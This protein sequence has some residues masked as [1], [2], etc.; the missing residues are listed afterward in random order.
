MKSRK[1]F[2]IDPTQLIVLGFMLIIL[3]G[4]ML[5]TLPIASKEGVFTDFISALFTATSATCVTGLVVV[6]TYLYWSP[7]GQAVILI[8]IQIGGLG[9]MTMATLFS[10]AIRRNISYKERMLVAQSLSFFDMK[11]V[12]R[13]TRHILLG[14]L[15]FEGT[16]AVILS[17][18]LIPEFGIAGG[19]YRGIFLSVSSFCNAGFDLMGSKGA[20]SSLTT[21]VD[22]ITVNAVVASLIIIGGLG[23]IVW[24]ELYTLRSFTK[25]SVYSKIVLIS[26]GVLIIGGAILIFLSEAENPATLQPLSVQGK[27]LA[28]LFQSVTPRTAGFNTIPLDNLHD[29]TAVIMILLMFIGA[30]SGSTGGGIKV[31]TASLLIFTFISVMKGRKDVV[32]MKKHISEDTVLRA[33][34]L[35]FMAFGLVVVFSIIIAFTNDFD[36]LSII[37]ECVSAF[38]TVGLT[39]G[40][41]PY[42]S[43]LAHILLIILM[44]LGRVGILTI[45]Y[46]IFM[47]LKQA[48]EKIEYPETKILIG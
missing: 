1:L 40:I 39:V 10:L 32:V 25:L 16:G 47:R 34:A 28:S 14:T 42:L 27:I 38:A 26:T 24:E 46:A 31:S 20:F 36:F 5:L 13:T 4:A 15:M 30:G 48:N 21:Y 17:A 2:K 44:F 7:F 33:F 6:D 35:T 29:I 43:D 8:L 23:F 19:I 18:R 41:T 45:T 37:F 12:I 9:F 22:D 3:F 11:G